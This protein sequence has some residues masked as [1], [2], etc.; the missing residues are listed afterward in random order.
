MMRRDRDVEAELNLPPGFRF[1]P[2]DEELVV[3]YLC[4]KISYQRL[5]VPII[6]EVDLYKY[7]PWQLPEKA[8]FGTKEWYFFSPRDRKYPNGSRPNRAAR[9]GYWKATGADKPIRPKGSEK[10]V[11]IK[12]ALVF[13]SGKA[14]KGVKTNWIMHEY[15]LAEPKRTSNKNSSLRLEGWVLCR[16][17]NKK[18]NWEITENRKEEQSV[19]ETMDSSMVAEEDTGSDSIRTIESDVEN[20]LPTEFIYHTA[21]QSN[22]PQTVEFKQERLVKEEDNSNWFTDL[23]LDDLKNSFT[24]FGEQPTM[25]LSFQDYYFAGLNSPHLNPYQTNLLPF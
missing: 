3:H 2:T 1:H 7:D 9:S 21:S 17:Y 10:N 8:L 15:R 6:A 14:P 11:G 19:E 25:D 5:P 18:N 12:K 20:D 13:Y 24:M 4:R 16:L 23:N 22:K